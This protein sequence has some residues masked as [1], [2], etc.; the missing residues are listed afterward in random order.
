MV[1]LPRVTGMA[2]GWF[3]IVRE[4]RNMDVPEIIIRMVMVIVFV[5]LMP[6]S[7]V[8]LLSIVVIHTMHIPILHVN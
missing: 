4:F 1:A 7:A 6:I 2:M 3:E 8:N 5:L